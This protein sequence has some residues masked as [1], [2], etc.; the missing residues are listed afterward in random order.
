MRFVSEKEG[1]NDRSGL[2]TGRVAI[3]AAM[4]SCGVIGAGL[5]IPWRLDEDMRRFR[6]L[7]LG[8]P[9][10]MGR[11]TY[12]SI[13]SPLP[14]RRNVVVST[15]MEACAGLE[16]VRSFT[17]ALALVFDAPEIMVCGGE[18]IYREAL[19]VADV[20]YLTRLD[21]CFLGD[22]KFPYVDWS[23]W[24]ESERERVELSRHPHVNV[25][26]ERLKSSG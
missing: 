2:G 14:H 26:Y 8:K 17:D 11:R 3:I 5:E 13:G 4:D 15:R 21:E 24:R 18:A 7:T 23:I 1:R 6:G 16:V 12:E 22:V 19:K 10:V 9:V 25:T 20:M